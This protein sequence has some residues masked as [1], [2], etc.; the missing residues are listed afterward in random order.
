[1]ILSLEQSMP[2]QLRSTFKRLF[3]QT[4]VFVTIIYVA[5]GTSGYLS[6]GPDTKQII[7]LNLEPA[8]GIDFA[9]IVKMCLCFS[10]FFTYPV[11]MF[12]VT[13]IITP[14]IQQW[15]A[16]EVSSSYKY[17]AQAFTSLQ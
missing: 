7:T 2:D 13:K 11:M 8:G 12:P 14:K 16:I 17:G 10:L 9:I 1:M 5:F 4:L 6:F 15:I 3:V